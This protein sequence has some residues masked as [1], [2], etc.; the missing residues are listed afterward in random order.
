MLVYPCKETRED[1]RKSKFMGKSYMNVRWVMKE[2]SFREG[3][4]L[5][6]ER[7]VTEGGKRRSNASV[8]G[9]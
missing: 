6:R 4:Y 8:K 5:V 1:G 2:G 3:S 7:W 9:M